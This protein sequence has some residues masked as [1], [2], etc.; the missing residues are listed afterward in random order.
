MSFDKLLQSFYYKNFRGSSAVKEAIEDIKIENLY[1]KTQIPKNLGLFDKKVLK[2]DDEIRSFK[3]FLF[4]FYP[5]FFFVI[6][7]INDEK[8]GVK[9]CNRIHIEKCF[10]EIIYINTGDNESV[11]NESVSSEST[12]NESTV[13]ESANDDKSV[14]SDISYTSAVS[15]TTIYAPKKLSYAPYGRSERILEQDK[16]EQVKKEQ[17]KKEQV[18]KEQ[19]KKQEIQEQLNSKKKPCAFFETKKGCYN[20]DECSFKH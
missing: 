20:G 2:D 18:K 10:V 6:K 8:I 11:S 15:F 13:N 19:V 5:D 17:V 9:V 4:N 7:P 1:S 12:V 3:A 14:T 16:K